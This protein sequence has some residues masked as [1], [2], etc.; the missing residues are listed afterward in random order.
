MSDE[1]EED[2]ERISSLTST[3]LL[4][5]DLEG[6]DNSDGEEKEEEEDGKRT[7]I[8]TKEMIRKKLH[9]GT[10][11]VSTL[12]GVGAGGMRYG[13]VELDPALSRGKLLECVPHRDD[14]TCGGQNEESCS[15]YKSYLTTNQPGCSEAAATST[16]PRC[17]QMSIDVYVTICEEHL[18]YADSDILF[19]RQLYQVINDSGS[20]GVQRSSLDGHMA[21]CHL[22]CTLSLEE[23]IHF[24]INF[25]MVSLFIKT[26]VLMPMAF[27]LVVLTLLLHCFPSLLL[28]PSLLSLPP[29]LPSLSLPPSLPLPLPPP[30]SLSLPFRCAWW[31]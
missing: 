20:N 12:F 6:G 1:E 30:P 8:F 26:S 21:L 27:T 16:S 31:V 11:G 25:E 7:S 13:F 10:G 18:K 17:E 28:P 24:L 3:Q 9:Y 15:R 22:H 23:H 19:T 4:E 29:T 2:E 14:G 5:D